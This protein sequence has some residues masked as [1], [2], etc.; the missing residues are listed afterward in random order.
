[1]FWAIGPI[2]ILITGLIGSKG[3]IRESLSG[4]KRKLWP[5]VKMY[6]CYS[7]VK[8]LFIYLFVPQFFRGIS[9]NML[10]ALT[11]SLF[12]YVQHNY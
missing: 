3:D 1:L 2:K 9:S 10:S 8:K 6:W 5:T 4:V 12:S 11:S 7:P